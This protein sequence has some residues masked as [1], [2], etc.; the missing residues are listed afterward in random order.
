MSYIRINPN[1]TV[2]TLTVAGQNTYS[3][4][5]GSNTSVTVTFD[6]PAGYKL[7]SANPTDLGGTN[8]VTRSFYFPIGGIAATWYLHNLGTTAVN[9]A[10]LKLSANCIKVS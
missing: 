3:C 6:I 8:M 9:N 2:E 1:P 10:T 5:A 4:A 7:V